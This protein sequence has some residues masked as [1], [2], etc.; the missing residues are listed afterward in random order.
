MFLASYSKRRLNDRRAGD[1]IQLENNWASNS[2]PNIAFDNPG[3]NQDAV[4]DSISPATGSTIQANLKQEKEGDK[5]ELHFPDDKAVNNLACKVADDSHEGITAYESLEQGGRSNPTYGI[6]YPGYNETEDP[7]E[8]Y[9]ALQG[10]ETS[11]VSL[12]TTGGVA[13]PLHE[14]KEYMTPLEAQSKVPR[15]AS[16]TAV[17]GYYEDVKDESQ[18]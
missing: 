11:Y 4:Y 7:P 12:S 13:N 14:D 8:Q 17:D 10:P 1:S 9:A 16:D 6:A 3:F 18:A 5:D 15:D 2:Y